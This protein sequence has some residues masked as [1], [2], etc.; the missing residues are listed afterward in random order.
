MVGLMLLYKKEEARDPSLCSPSRERTGDLQSR[1]SGVTSHHISCVLI[2]KFPASRNVR[3]ACLWF[4]PPSLW[5]SCYSP[6]LK[7]TT[8][9]IRDN[10]GLFAFTTSSQHFTRVLR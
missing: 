1:K 10:A 5:Y 9:E 4:K 3:N 8:P 6:K 7:K 2:L